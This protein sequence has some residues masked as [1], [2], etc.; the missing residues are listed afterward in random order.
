MKVQ[1]GGTTATRVNQKEQHKST[2]A[3][4]KYS[5]EQPGNHPKGT[6]PLRVCVCVCVCVCA[7]SLQLCPTLCNPMECSPAGSSVHGILQAGILEWVAMPSSR[8][9]S[10]PRDQTHISWVCCI[11]RTHFVYHQHH[12][13]S[14]TQSQSVTKGSPLQG[15]EPV[16]A[17]VPKS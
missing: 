11:G 10:C 5:Q 17:L 2:P 16:L 7:K 14:P 9:S 6:A 13:R 8:G 4:N 15:Q 3:H 12:L 1:Q